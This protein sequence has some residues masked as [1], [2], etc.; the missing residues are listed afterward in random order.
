M[1]LKRTKK[2]VQRKKKCG[3]NKVLLAFQLEFGTRFS[4]PVPVFMQIG[5]GQPS[6]SCRQCWTDTGMQDLK[7]HKKKKFQKI[8]KNK[9]IIGNVV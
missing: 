5:T 2:S 4:I 9:L 3:Q 7:N 8:K 1:K 6:R